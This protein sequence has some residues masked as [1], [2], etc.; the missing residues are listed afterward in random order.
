MLRPWK[1]VVGVVLGVAALPCS[2]MAATTITITTP[3]NGASYTV[4]Q[5]VQVSFSCTEAVDC[6][7]TDSHNAPLAQGAMLDTS[8]AGPGY[9]TVT[10]HDSSG[11]QSTQQSAYSVVTSGDG[12]AGGS[13][14]ATLNLTL[15]Q[16]GTL[17][18]VRP[19][20][21]RRTSCR[22]SPRASS[23]RRVTRRSPSPTRAPCRPATWSTV[24]SSCRRPPG[25]RAQGERHLDGPGHDG[26]DR[27]QLRPD[28]AADLRRPG[29]R[30]RDHHLQAAA[31]GH[32]GAAHG[33][34]H[35]DAHLHAVDHESVGSRARFHL[36]DGRPT[37][38]PSWLTSP[39]AQA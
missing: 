5:P 1:V 36:H 17:A 15:G 32:R 21:R 29:Q 13:T 19:G 30:D 16:A 33:L 2:A 25:R 9:I 24:T 37:G 7:A 6:T 11:A 14:P 18:A 12:G 31:R 39:H 27:W 8:T 28:A 10:A 20:C 4:G 35:Q 26:R 3:P 23:P 22:R 38:R 34:L